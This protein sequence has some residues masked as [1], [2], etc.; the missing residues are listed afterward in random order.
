MSANNGYDMG[1][2]LSTRKADIV[3]V[4]PHFRGLATKRGL[5]FA[6][7]AKIRKTCKNGIGKINFL[8]YSYCIQNVNSLT[9]TNTIIMHI[10]LH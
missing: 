6:I 2:D 3:L 1:V 7:M 8:H 4:P 9:T 5:V 10:R